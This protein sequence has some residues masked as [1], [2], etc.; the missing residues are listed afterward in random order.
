MLPFA[1]LAHKKLLITHYFIVLVLPLA[2]NLEGLQHFGLL[3]VVKFMHLPEVS[4]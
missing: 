4:F 3:I 2:S 1:E